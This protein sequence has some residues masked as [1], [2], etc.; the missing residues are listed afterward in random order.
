M[1]GN[2]V[3]QLNYMNKIK[4][5]LIIQLRKCFFSIILFNYLFYRNRMDALIKEKNFDQ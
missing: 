3:Y 4:K 1:L 5:I 2:R